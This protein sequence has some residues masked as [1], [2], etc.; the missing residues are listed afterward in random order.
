MTGTLR[1]AQ[2]HVPDYTLLLQSL[3]NPRQSELFQ[4][5]FLTVRL[6]E[7]LVSVLSELFVEV[8]QKNGI[9]K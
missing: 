8:Y 5:L 1:S 6:A 4:I 7:I 3:Q 9:S 2:V